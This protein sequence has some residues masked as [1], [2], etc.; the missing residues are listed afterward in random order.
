MIRY[1]CRPPLLHLGPA[2][3][4]AATPAGTAPGPAAADQAAT[5]FRLD[6]PTVPEATPASGTGS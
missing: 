5:R 4:T 1:G 6:P 3:T 2:T